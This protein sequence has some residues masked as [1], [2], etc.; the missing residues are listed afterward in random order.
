MDA[1]RFAGGTAVVTGAASGIGAALATELAARGSHL[2][3]VDRDGERLDGVADGVRRDH[4]HLAVD[5]C[6]VDLST[7][8]PPPRRPRRSPPHTRGRRCWSTTPASRSE[9]GSTR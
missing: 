9:G 3:L 8:R 2:V 6:M 5:T 1:Y 7:T 4:P